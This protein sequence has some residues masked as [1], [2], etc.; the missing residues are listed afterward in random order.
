MAV[1]GREKVWVASEERLRGATLR[2]YDDKG[3]L[4]WDASG[5]R[6]HGDKADHSIG[7]PQR[8]RMVR[9][10]VRWWALSA[11]AVM[12]GTGGW[13]L[14]PTLPFVALGI[15]LGALVGL[16]IVVFVARRNQWI[17]ISGSDASLAVVASS[18]SYANPGG[19]PTR[20]LARELAHTFGVALE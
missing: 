6:V 9:P 20:R 7:T 18:M 10:A 4:V 12:F 5:V 16:S 14:L 19:A 1:S 2:A 13:L 15:W 3:V 17:L 8:M 11:Y